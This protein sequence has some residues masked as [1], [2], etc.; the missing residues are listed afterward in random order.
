[1]NHLYSRFLPSLLFFVFFFACSFKQ[2]TSVREKNRGFAPDNVSVEKTGPGKSP[3]DVLKEVYGKSYAVVIGIDEYTAGMKRLTG[4]VRDA[5][6]VA[7]SLKGRGFEVTLITDEAA[8]KTR[9]RTLPFELQE[10]LNPDDRLFF[11]FAGHGVDKRGSGYLMPSDGKSWRDGINMSVMQM[12]LESTQVRQI[13]YASDACYS[14]LGLPSALRAGEEPTMP[15]HWKEAAAKQRYVSLSAGGKGE[16]AYD[17]FTG[18]TGKGPHGLFTY[19]L[20]DGL[21]GFADS[22]SDGWITDVELYTHVSNQV[23]PAARKLNHKQNPAVGYS[24]EGRVLFANPRI[25]ELKSRENLIKTSGENHPNYRVGKNAFD[26]GFWEMA[27]EELQLCVQSDPLNINCHWLLGKVHEKNGSWKDA[28]HSWRTVEKHDPN[29]PNLKDKLVKAELETKKNM[30]LKNSG[31]F[32][33]HD[34]T[35]NACNQCFSDADCG[36]VEKT[37]LSDGDRE[38]SNERWTGDSVIEFS[39]PGYLGYGNYGLYVSEKRLRYIGGGLGSVSNVIVAKACEGAPPKFLDPEKECKSRDSQLNEEDIDCLKKIC[40]SF[41]ATNDWMDKNCGVRYARFENCDPVN[42]PPFL[43]LDIEENSPLTNAFKPL[44]DKHRDGNFLMRYQTYGA[45]GF[46]GTE[47][48]IKTHQDKIFSYEKGI[49]GC[50]DNGSKFL[51]AERC[52]FELKM[53][54]VNC[55]LDVDEECDAAIQK[56]QEQIQKHIIKNCREIKQGD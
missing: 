11:Y 35:A 56:R 14:G 42:I 4:A 32:C 27:Q 15:G 41:S 52:K 19:F 13:F 8:N 17:S 10:K 45:S 16:T 2:T 5:K 18:D 36:G 39:F 20:L 40:T 1:M 33:H 7:E 50:A 49:E 3:E 30:A 53:E 37:C 23:P 25:K 55:V 46:C 31:G 38:C 6:A 34:S 12:Q 24:G 29:F 9:L 22:D 21:D 28:L 51:I 26:Q 44:V 54:E 48:S 43:S 47:T